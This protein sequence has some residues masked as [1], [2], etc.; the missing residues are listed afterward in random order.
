MLIVGVLVLGFIVESTWRSLLERVFDQI[1]RPIPLVSSIHDLAKRFVS[2]VE[3]GGN[4]DINHMSPVW[5]FFGGEGGAA[6]LG[7]MPSPQP[8]LVGE[9]Q[10]LAVLIP[11]APVP[12]GGC[13]IYVPSAWVKPAKGGIE[14]L[15]SVYASMGL[16]PPEQIQKHHPSNG[17]RPQT[18]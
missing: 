4:D 3:P 12:I 7:L 15:M 17:N 14:R 2:M 16:T 1:I 13:L 11:S 6:V 18:D 10:Y 8:V 5:C 9:N